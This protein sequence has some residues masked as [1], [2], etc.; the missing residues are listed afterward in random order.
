MK[1]SKARDSALCVKRLLF[2]CPVCIPLQS[3]QSSPCLQV[4][5]PEYGRILITRRDIL[6]IL[7]QVSGDIQNGK[8]KRREKS[9]ASCSS[10]SQ[11]GLTRCE[12]RCDL[13]PF[14]LHLKSTFLPRKKSPQIILYRSY[15]LK[16]YFSCLAVLILV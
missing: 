14:F 2:L 10:Y 15:M 12:Y 8:G 5:P 16:S 9:N 6:L 13:L 4:H 3:H 7:R 1:N 11:M